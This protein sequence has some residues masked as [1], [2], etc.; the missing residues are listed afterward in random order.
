M[1]FPKQIPGSLDHLTVTPSSDKVNVGESSLQV[2]PLTTFLGCFFPS[3]F[4][5]IMSVLPEKFLQ[6][7]GL[8]PPSPPGSYAY[9]HWCLHCMLASYR[10][11]V[12]Q[13]I[14]LVKMVNRCF[15]RKE[16]FGGTSSKVLTAALWESRVRKLGEFFVHVTVTN[17]STWLV[18]KLFWLVNQTCH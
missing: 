16:W 1:A 9:E 4:A 5:W 12:E 11:K 18:K 10:V 15:K 3:T 17:V 14:L 8:K 6:L 13:I 2:W 7:G